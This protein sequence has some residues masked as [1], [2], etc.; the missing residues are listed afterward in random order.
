[1]DVIVC[2][3]RSCD[4]PA[5]RQFI[6]DE[7]S[8]FDEVFVVLTPPSGQNISGFIRANFPEATFIDAPRVGEWR[9]AAVNAALDQSTASHVWFTEQDFLVTDPAVFWPQ[10][11]GDLAGVCVDE[12]PLHPACLLASRELIEQTSRDFSSGIDH[13]DAFGRE[14]MALADP[15]IISGGYRHLQGISESQMLAAD[16]QPPRFLP[17]QFREWVAT[18][19]AADVPIEP[20]WRAVVA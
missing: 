8:R 9:D 6:R 17:E 13:F 7:R 18:N 20:G 1:M 19:L 4:Y 5:W 12:R 11:T 16:G 3:P 10:L 14:L 2:W 15:A